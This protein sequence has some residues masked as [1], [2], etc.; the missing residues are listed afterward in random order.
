MIKLLVASIFLN[1]TPLDHDIHVSICDI[2]VNSD[3]I[4]LT[5]K[6]F[7]DDLQLAVG[8]TPGEELP[9]DYT[10]AD[11]LIG[12]YLSSSIQL[13][14]GDMLIPLSINDMTAS[15][16]AIWITIVTDLPKT[17]SSI[18]ITN[19]FLTELYRDQTNLVNIKYGNEKESF[20][21]DTKKIEIVYKLD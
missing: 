21:L 14:F 6:T 9:D 18:S 13:R 4:E 2:E 20:I 11:E 12:N 7:L 1:L 15:Q 10:S 17:V 16:D 8:L 19:K 3:Q 5:L